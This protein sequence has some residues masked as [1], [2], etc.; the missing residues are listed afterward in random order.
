[1]QSTNKELNLTEH[2]TENS[3]DN[4]FTDDPQISFF[5]PTK[6]KTYYPFARNTI[7]VEFKEK[8]DFG[9]TVTVELPTKGDLISR[10]FVEIDLPT[11]IPNNTSASYVNNVGMAIFD[12]MEIEVGGQ[13][14]GKIYSE[15]AHIW[16][17]LTTTGEQRI[18]VNWMT[19]N[20]DSFTTNSFT[21]GK[22]FVPLYFWFNNKINQAFPIGAITHNKV[23]MRFKTKSFNDLWVSDNNIAPTGTYSI[24]NAKLLIDYYMISK[25]ESINFI[26]VPHTYLIHQIQQ[27]SQ[28]IGAGT[29]SYNVDISQ[30]RN[31]ITEI[32]WVLQRSDART[33]KDWFNY[34]DVLTGTS[35][36]PLL[37]ARIYYEGDERTELLSGQYFR[38]VE[39]FNRHTIIPNDYIY[40]YLFS[41]YPENTSQPSGVVNMGKLHNISLYLELK[42]GLPEMYITVYAINYK[43][44]IVANGQ[45]YLKHTFNNTF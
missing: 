10:M 28:S 35:N 9:K 45:A 32:I 36:D 44:L 23:I 20:F 5:Q 6:N 38:T 19:R 8:F 15:F 13:V 12:W 43:Q 3:L 26:N 18:G 27:V 17:I 1:M 34:S 33:N 2:N 11:L 40:M 7:S 25:K 16:N 37:K 41:L 42:S 14:I 4:Y 21:G 30:F 24:E 31:T 22:L 39:P 29:T